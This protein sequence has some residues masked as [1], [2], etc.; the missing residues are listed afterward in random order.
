M[1]KELTIPDDDFDI[2]IL[3][4][5]LLVVATVMVVIPMLPVIQSAQSYFTSQSY[6][7]KADPREVDANSSLQYFDLYASPGVPWSWVHFFNN[8]P[9]TVKIGINSWE[10]MFEILPF[11]HFTVSRL[12]AKER[13]GIIYY[14]CVSPGRAHVEINGEY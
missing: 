9:N 7:G 4:T 13:I 6:E 3:M 14:T 8:G 1:A 12:G 10:N 11:Q 2:G 5:P